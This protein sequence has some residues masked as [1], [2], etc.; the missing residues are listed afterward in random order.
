ML[1]TDYFKKQTT[2]AADVRTIFPHFP[3]ESLYT[4]LRIL[5]DGIKILAMNFATALFFL[6]ITFTYKPT[7]AMNADVQVP[8]QIVGSLSLGQGSLEALKLTG[9]DSLKL[10]MKSWEKTGDIKIIHAYNIY[11]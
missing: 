2:I 5:V 8:V 4:F 7:S 6:R 3:Y 11:I 10:L 1:R 9:I